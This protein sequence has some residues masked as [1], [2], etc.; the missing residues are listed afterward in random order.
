VGR[1]LDR[2]FVLLTLAGALARSLCCYSPVLSYYFTDL[3]A[4]LDVAEALPRAP[5]R[6][7]SA[8][9]GR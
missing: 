8:P 6:R 7:A 3:G 1:S 2:R 9:Q 4:F 5:G